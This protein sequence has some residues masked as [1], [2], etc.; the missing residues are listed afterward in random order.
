MNITIIGCGDV[1]TRCATLLREH[2]RITAARRNID[3]LPAWPGKRHCDVGDATS[4]GW[5]ADHPTDVLIYSLAAASFQDADYQ[6]AYVTG[7]QNVLSALADQLTSVKRVIFV[8]STGVY[9]QDDGSVV[10]EN[11]ATKPVRFNGQ[12]VLEGERL[13]NATGKGSCV[14]FSGIYGPGRL[15]MINRVASGNFTPAAKAK[16]TN[17]IHVDDCAGALAHI[18]GLVESDA[19]ENCYLASDDRPASNVEVETFIATELGLTYTAAAETNSYNAGGRIAGSKICSNARLRASGY[20][21]LYPDFE[22]GY[23]QLIGSL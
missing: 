1:G 6:L 3:A 17:R 12:R 8:S 14:R 21:F 22:S 2:H 4:L 15:R 7:V 9:H 11:S 19:V 10:D 5:L 13:V 16:L 18:V 20:E 23:R